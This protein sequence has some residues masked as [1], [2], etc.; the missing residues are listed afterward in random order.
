ME[1][2]YFIQMIVLFGIMFVGSQYLIDSLILRSLTIEESYI[3]YHLIC[4]LLIKCG[5]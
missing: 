4:T 1:L 5:V 3:L 2:I